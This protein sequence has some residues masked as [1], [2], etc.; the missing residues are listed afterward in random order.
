MPRSQV[1]H[2]PLRDHRED[3]I[4]ALRELFSCDTLPEVISLTC[5]GDVMVY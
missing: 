5:N 4:H 3:S 2:S 1:L